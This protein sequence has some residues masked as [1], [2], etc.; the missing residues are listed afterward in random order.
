MKV[1]LTSLVV[2]L[3]DDGYILVQ[4]KGLVIVDNRIDRKPTNTLFDKRLCCEEMYSRFVYQ[5]IVICRVTTS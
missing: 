1:Y 2:L 5:V 4:E 3:G